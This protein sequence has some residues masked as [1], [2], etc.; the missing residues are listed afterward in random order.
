[1]TGW[2]LTLEVEFTATRNHKQQML[3]LP[4]PTTPFYRHS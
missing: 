4:E 3:H 1:M 2:A